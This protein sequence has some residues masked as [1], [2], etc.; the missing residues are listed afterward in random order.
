MNIHACHDL[1]VFIGY[2]LEFH[3]NNIHTQLTI[4]IVEK[5]VDGLFRDSLGKF[6]GSLGE[7]LYPTPL[8]GIIALNIN[9]ISLSGIPI[10]FN[11]GLSNLFFTS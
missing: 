10:D 4:Q 8:T 3:F 11:F 5:G 9:L 2:F 6:Q 7:N 1:C